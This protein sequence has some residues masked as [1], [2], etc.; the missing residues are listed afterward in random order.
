MYVSTTSSSLL[1]R[2]PESSCPLLGRFTR[3]KAV[4]LQC[5][6]IGYLTT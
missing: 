2:I 3:S 4:T 5:W 6:V 1:T